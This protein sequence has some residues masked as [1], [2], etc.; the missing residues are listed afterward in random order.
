[1]PAKYILRLLTI[2][3][4]T[5]AIDRK[6]TSAENAGY[7]QCLVHAGT[8]TIQSKVVILEGSA[9]H[10]LDSR[11]PPN[12]N[13]DS[14]EDLKYFKSLKYCYKHQGFKIQQITSRIQNLKRFEYF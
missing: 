13:Q 5:Y 7:Q 6:G 14:S 10:N 8:G 4:N 3:W 1:M 11:F 12:L 9:M 2:S